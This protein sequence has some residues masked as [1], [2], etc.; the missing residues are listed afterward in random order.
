MNLSQDVNF[1]EILETKEKLTGADIKS[2]IIEAG[3]LAL[4]ERRLIVY[5]NDF[6]K[7]LEKTLI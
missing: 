4:K 3:L 1:N 6:K 2:I 7:G 5:Q